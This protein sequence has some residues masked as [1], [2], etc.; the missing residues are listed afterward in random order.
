MHS[1]PPYPVE[2]LYRPAAS[3]RVRPKTRGNYVQHCNLVYAEAHG[4]GL[5]MDVFTPKQNASGL[6]VVDVISSGW[7]SDRT[8]LNEHIGFGIID[9]LCERGITVFAVSP[10]SVTLFTAGE[11]VRHVQAAIRHIK[12]NANHY[13]IKAEPLGLLGVSAGG[14]LGALAAL[15]PKHG[16]PGAHDPL[17]RWNTDVAAA[18][19]F[20]PP[21]DLVDYGGVRFDRIRVEGL[22]LG[23]LLFRNGTEG[24]EEKALLDTLTALSPARIPLHHP[25]PFLIV[26]GKADPVVPWRQ[27][28]KLAASLRGAS[29]SVRLIYKEDGGHLW[30]DIG[31]EI[32]EAAQWMD[33]TLRGTGS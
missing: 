21:T 7:L 27:A 2:I 6:A 25:P 5:V 33:A 22:E 18:A 1:S 13:G 29:G 20:F 26:Q 28:E 19:V 12:N 32:E 8:T 15:S 10:G 16:R 3:L 23:S 24:V 11:M 31:V 17:R 30:P 9:A 14:H 4:I